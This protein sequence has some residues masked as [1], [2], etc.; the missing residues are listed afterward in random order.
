MGNDFLTRLAQAQIPELNRMLSALDT[1]IDFS[2]RAEFHFQDSIGT[3]QQDSP[4]RSMADL[5]LGLFGTR[6]GIDRNTREILES[7][8]EVNSSQVQDHILSR[9]QES[10]S[11]LE[12]NVRKL[13]Q[14]VSRIAVLALARARK[15]QQEGTPAVEAVLLRL[16]TVEKEIIATRDLQPPQDQFPPDE[17][18]ELLQGTLSA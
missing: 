16:N 8:L 12:T 4:L 2:V 1:E 18:A 10:R 13:L 9:M 11:R 7:L 6:K 17:Q 5:S 3:A 15:T 14:Q